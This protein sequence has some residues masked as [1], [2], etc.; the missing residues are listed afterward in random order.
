MGVRRKHLREANSKTSKVM[1]RAYKS[2]RISLHLSNDLSLNKKFKSDKRWRRVERLWSYEWWLR[3][4][5][6]KME[7]EE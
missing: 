7:V 1:Y 5:A 4:N 6:R 3:M 2:G